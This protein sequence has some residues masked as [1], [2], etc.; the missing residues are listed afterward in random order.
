MSC[1]RVQTI[2]TGSLDLLGDENRLPDIFLNRRAPA[3]AAA[4]HRACMVT[5]SWDTPAAS[6]AVATAVAGSCDGAQISTPSA[7]TCAVQFCGSMVA[8]ARNGTA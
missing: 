4:E 8:C 5:L 3:E 2:L 7:F 1:S 6:A